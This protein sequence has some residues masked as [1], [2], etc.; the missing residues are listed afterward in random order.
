M[1]N[2]RFDTPTEDSTLDSWFS[3]SPLD[4]RIAPTA[5]EGKSPQA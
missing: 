1:Q 2:A 5:Q 4:S 3:D